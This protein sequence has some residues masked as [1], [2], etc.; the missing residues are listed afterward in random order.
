MVS[1]LLVEDEALI[2]LMIAD[3]LVELGHKVAGEAGDLQTGL[4]LASAAVIDV[5]ILDVRLGPDSSEAIAD[6]LRTRNIPFV[7]ATGYG[8]DGVPASYRE[9]PALCKPFQ[10]EELDRCLRALRG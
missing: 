5:A 1:V 6:V 2:R 8:A 7:F 4:T 9:R 3:M 10:A